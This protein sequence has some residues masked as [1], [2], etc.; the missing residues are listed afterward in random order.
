MIAPPASA[1]SVNVKPASA[2]SARVRANPPGASV[3][4]IESPHGDQAPV[5]P[6]ASAA[7]S[8]QAVSTAPSD[9]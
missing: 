6:A 7:A 5:T 1:P 2:D 4:T 8:R 9:W 3:S